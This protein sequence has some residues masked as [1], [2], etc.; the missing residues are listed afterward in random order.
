M[1]KKLM[2]ISLTVL[3]ASVSGLALAKQGGDAGGKSDAHMSTAGATNT[4]GPEA[5]DRDKSQARAE[6]RRSDEGAEHDK[7]GKHGKKH[8]DKK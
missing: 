8:P 5:V 3:L 2:A 7:A 4:N 6:D 1:L